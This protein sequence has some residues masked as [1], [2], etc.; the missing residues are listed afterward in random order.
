MIINVYAIKDL[1]V[2]AFLQPFFSQTHG[3]AIRAFAD[4][5]ADKQS[6]P[7]KHPEDFILYSIGKYDDQTGQLESGTLQQ[8]AQATEYANGNA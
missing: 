7:N 1:K 2:N 6:M 3:S 8:L 5:C 4:H